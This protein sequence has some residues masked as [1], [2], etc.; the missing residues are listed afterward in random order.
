[1][2][3]NWRWLTQAI[4]LLLFGFLTFHAAAAATRI[5]VQ[6]KRHILDS[7]DPGRTE[8]GKL[9]YLSGIV[10]SSDSPDFGG[11]SGLQISADGARLVAV[12]DAGK[13]LG[14]NLLYEK[15]QL[16]G[17]DQAEISPLLSEDGRA[18][19]NNKMVDAESLTAVEP[20]NLNGP[21]I[22]SFEGRHRVWRYAQGLAGRPEIVA[23]PRQLINAP[24]NG[25]IEAFDRR[26]DGVFIAL[27]EEWLDSNGNHTG[28]LIGKQMAHA[29]RLRREGEF[30][31]TDLEFLP[32]GDLLVLERRYSVLG[33]PGMQIRRIK[34]DAIKPDAMLDGEVL[35]NL[36][37]R[38][39]IDNFEGLATRRNA[40]G[41]IMIYMI[42]DN[43][44][45]MLQKNIVLMFKLAP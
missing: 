40:T 42:S 44:F 38:F 6:S 36:T 24:A 32:N 13:W 10:M 33:G 43:N 3:F 30:D 31:P 37:S 14:A 19:R 2:K 26:A 15:G 7:D 25:G 41:E 29:I 17:L 8:F 12:S 35:I 28:W 45:S 39:G 16:T 9:I 20:G 1:M 27:T 21:M 11:F 23:M 22:V 18:L 4:L 34:A 5:S